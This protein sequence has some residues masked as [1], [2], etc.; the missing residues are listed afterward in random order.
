VAKHMENNELLRQ[1]LV[2]VHGIV[3]FLRSGNT[4]TLPVKQQLLWARENPAA[5]DSALSMASI[6]G[7]NWGGLATATSMVKDGS[8]T[9]NDF[10]LQV[11]QHLIARVLLLLPNLKMLLALFL[12][13]PP[14]E[15]QATEST[16]DSHNAR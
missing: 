11:I 3:E 9:W 6:A 15:L 12:L 10:L 16:K 14:G 7:R 1:D 2:V 4:N 13:D 5:G 8:R